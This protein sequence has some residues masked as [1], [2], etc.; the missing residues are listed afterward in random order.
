MRGDGAGGEGGA[1]EEMCFRVLAAAGPTGEGREDR[2]LPRAV[3]L[4]LP[5]PPPRAL[6]QAWQRGRRGRQLVGLHGQVPAAAARRACRTG[7]CPKP[8]S[9]RKAS[10]GHQHRCLLGMLGHLMPPASVCGNGVLPSKF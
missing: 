7:W 8:V 1:R 3:H 4:K 9:R 6:R 2:G 5:R 10:F